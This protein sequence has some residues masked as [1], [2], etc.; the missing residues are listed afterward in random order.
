MLVLTSSF[1][2]FANRGDA[3]FPGW[4]DVPIRFGDALLVQGAA[5][6][7]DKLRFDGDFLV[8]ET[9]ELENAPAE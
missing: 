6:R 2:P 4:G 7:I 9:P 1:W 5:E 8:L 3:W